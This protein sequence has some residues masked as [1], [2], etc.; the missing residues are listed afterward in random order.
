MTYTREKVL[1][2]SG[3]ELDEAA[4]IAM[5]WEEKDHPGRIGNL[6]W[7]DEYEYPVYYKPDGTYIVSFGWYPSEDMMQALELLEYFDCAE[8]RKSIDH[9][10]NSIYTVQIG[11]VFLT[12]NDR[13]EWPRII[14]Q[15]VILATLGQGGKE[16]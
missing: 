1:N 15:A 16:S 11:S 5:G 7:M 3:Q 2:I 4:A 13:E 12:T 10:Q 14:T 6:R 9:D 8:L